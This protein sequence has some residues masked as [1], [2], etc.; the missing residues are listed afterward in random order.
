MTVIAFIIYPAPANSFN[1]ESLK[2]QAVCKQLRET[3]AKVKENIASRMFESSE[4]TVMGVPSVT[5]N[6]SG[7]GCFIEEHV[8]DPQTYGCYVID[9]RFKSAEESIDELAHHL[10]DFTCLSRRQRIIMRNRTE[11]LSELLD[12]KSLGVFYREARRMALQKTHPNLVDHISETIRKLPR[13]LSAPTTPATSNPG[14]PDA[15]DDESDS[16]AA[17]FEQRAWQG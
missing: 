16:E 9:R 13:P 2:G 14:S 12:W 11:R 5:T 4:C 17:E 6:L 10:F 15:S 7:F 8:T 3:V 1:V